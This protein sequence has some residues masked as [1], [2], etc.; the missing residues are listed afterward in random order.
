MKAIYTPVRASISAFFFCCFISTVSFAQ[1][2]IWS[3][4][5]AARPNGSTTGNQWQ[6]DFV[7]DCDPIPGTFNVVGSAFVIEDMEGS[8]CFGFDSGSND[9]LMTIGPID[10][11]SASCL[12]VGYTVTASGDFEISGPGADRLV[13][14]V[15]LDGATV[16]ASVYIS[17]NAIPGQGPRVFTLPSGNN[18]TI[19]IQGGTQS[20]SETYSISNMFIRDVGFEPNISN[21]S[22]CVDQVFPLLSLSAP[23]GPGVW[24]GQGVVANNWVTT[25]LTPG[26]YDLTFTPN[27][28]CGKATTVRG[29]LN[30]GGQAGDATIASC[31]STN[32]AIFDL[33]QA[34]NDIRDGASGQVVWYK[35]ANK[36]VQIF[37][38]TT[39]SATNG[40]IVYGAYLQSGSCPS[41]VGEVQ[42]QIQAPNPP[43]PVDDV[44]ACLS[45]TLPSLGAGLSYDSHS[46]GDVITADEVITIMTGSGACISS[47]SYQ[48]TILPAPDIDPYTGITE[49]CDSLQLPAITG[50]RLTGNEAYYTGTGGT[51]TRYDT[52]SYYKNI[53]ISTLYIYDGTGSCSD[54]ESFFVDLG[55]SASLNLQDTIVCDTF[56]FLPY[57][58]PGTFLG[59]YSEA[60]GGGTTYQAGD[61]IKSSPGTATYYARAGAGSCIVEDSFQVTFRLAPDIASISPFDVC[62]ALELP[63][64]AGDL[65][66]GNEAYFTQPGGQGLRFTEGTMI[67]KTTTLYVYDRIGSCYEELLFTVYVIPTPKLAAV[68]DTVVCD[69]LV[70]PV[71]EGTDLSGAQGYW[72]GRDGTGT[73]YDSGAVITTSQM[74]YL[75]DERARCNAQDSFQ[76]T[77]NVRPQITGPI[78]EEYVCDTF[79]LPA[80]TGNSL[81][82]NEVITTLPMGQGDTILAGTQYTDSTTL[83]LFGGV[84]GCYAEDSLRLYINPQPVLVGLPDVDT[85]DFWVLP[86]IEGQNLTSNVAY[87]DSPGGLGETY[88][89]GDTLEESGTYYI[90]DSTEIGCFAEDTF[91]LQIGITPILTHIPDT[92]ACGSFTLPAF[93]GENLQAPAYLD[94][95]FVPSQFF[96]EGQVI[97]TD[98]TIYIYDADLGCSDTTSFSVRVLPQVELETPYRDTMVCDSMS[99]EAILGQNLT[100]NEAYFDA[101]GGLGTSYR[102]GDIIRDSIRLFI[103]DGR[104]TCTDQDTLDIYVQPT[105]VL[106]PIADVAVCDF[107]ILPGLSGQNITA[108]AAYFDVNTGARFVAGDTIFVNRAMEAI[109]SN[110]FG[111]RSVQA[112]GIQITPTPQLA[113]IAD[114]E[115]CDSLVLP[116][117]SGQFL[118]S[119]VSYF[120]DTLGAGFRL[121]AG[122][123]IEVSQTLFVYADSLG[124]RDEASFAVSVNYT[125][126]VINAMKDTVGCFAVEIPVLNG[127]DLSPNTGYY[128]LPAGNGSLVTLPL[129]LVSDTTLYLFGNNATCTTSDTIDVQVKRIVTDILVTDSIECFGDAGQIELQNMISET[130]FNLSWNDPAF[131]GSEIL[132]GIPAGT[133]SVTITDPNN[134]TL[135]T[136]IVLPQPDLLVL[137]CSIANQVTVPNGS[138][139][140]I[141]LNLNGGTAPYTLFL[142]GDLTDTLVFNGSA[143][144]QLDTLA[145]GNYSFMLV[146][147]LGCA[148][149]CSQT[150]T[151]PPCE[152]S[153]D[154]QAND[155]SCAGQNNGQIMAVITN[156]QAPLQIVWNDTTFN[157]MTDLTNLMAGDY[158]VMVT[159]VN[160]CVDSAQATIIDPAPLTISVSQAQPVSGPD[161][162]DGVANL[163]FTGG[164]A[165]YQIVYDGPQTDTIS[166]NSPTGLSVDS[167]PQG[168]YIFGVID[169]NNCRISATVTITN[170][171]CGMSVTINK[172]DQQCPNTVDGELIPIVSGGVAPYQFIWSDGVTDSIRSNLPEGIYNLTVL[173]DDNCVTAVSDTIRVANP[174]PSLALVSDTVRCDSTCQSFEL[175]LNGTAPFNFSWELSR[176]LDG[177]IDTQTG[178]VGAA[179][180]PDEVLTFCESANRMTL[181]VNTLEDANCRL[182][183][184][185][186][187][188]L[189]I[190]PVPVLLLNDT[191]CQDDTRTIEGQVFD[192]SHPADTIRLINQAANGCDS[193]LLVNLTFQ[194]TVF[195]TLQETICREDSLV[196][197][198]NVYNFDVPGGTETFFGQ[199]ATGCDSVLFIDLSFYPIDTNFVSATLCDQEVFTVA[200][201]I[202]DVNRPSGLVVLPGAATTG[203][204]SIISVDINFVPEYRTDI[205]E[206]ICLEDSLIVNGNRY[207]RFRLSGT[208]TIQTAGGCDSIITI[209]LSLFPVDTTYYIQTLCPGDS[210][211]VN[212]VLYNKTNLSGIQTLENAAATGCDSIISVSIDYYPEIRTSYQDTL[213]YLDSLEVN[214][215]I[216]H[217][218]RP[219]G[220][221]IFEG[222]GRNGCDSIVEIDLEFREPVM[223]SLS[224]STAIC[225]GETA[226]LVLELSGADVYT[227]YYQRDSDV[228]I[229]LEGLVDGATIPVSPVQTSIYQ[230]MAVE[231]EGPVCAGTPYGE[232]VQVTVSEM[233]INLEQSVDYNGFGVSCAGATDG[234]LQVD[235]SGGVE[236]YNYQWSNGRFGASITGLAAGTYAVTIVD[237][238][239][240]Q[241]SISQILLEPSVLSISTD[242]YSSKCSTNPNGA[243][244]LNSV[245]GGVMP[246]EYSLDGPYFLP[247]SSLP[248][249]AGNLAPGDYDFQVQDNNG[250][251]VS[252]A[253]TIEEENLEITFQPIDDLHIG[254]SV[255]LIPEANFDLTDFTWRPLDF[256][257]DSRSSQP[258]VSPERTTIYTITAV[259]S[260]GCQVSAMITVFVDQQRR[261]YAPTAFTPNEDGYN[262]RFTIFGASDLSVIEILQIYDR[263]G[264]LLY[265]EE[266]LPPNDDHFG[267]NGEHRDNR[268][269]TGP[270]VYRAILRFSNGSREEVK[271]EVALFR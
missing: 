25:G 236:P 177:Q 63:A 47:T 12:Q 251:Q 210:L 87:Y 16:A 35:D 117:I 151:A 54:E 225:A 38:P 262:D 164:T 107:Y 62:D 104:E 250:C 156:S 22:A 146:D 162:N 175:S 192:R 261:V 213:C 219:S 270:Y 41:E 190:L 199:S 4:D 49:A 132:N 28:P 109:D 193:L 233:N 153:V 212:G 226:N 169:A 140:R 45:Y 239:G 92:L 271:G 122:T 263:W 95:P 125:P 209:D 123:K 245:S 79:S 36:S 256:L 157:G 161:A 6:V 204:D 228:P 37:N 46:V 254:D 102:A 72:T 59:Y 139:G 182:T 53:G 168:V 77:V 51:G 115:V 57:T 229:R 1:T 191:L 66:S 44:E 205:T 112:F 166:S 124:C 246:Y 137:D 29:T 196:I 248:M 234:S 150:I 5:F 222:Q 218:G 81:F 158:S 189:E 216:Y 252:T 84:E 27:D 232:K 223:A 68:E 152:L 101:P 145:A 147:G 130:P 176:E 19:Q 103:F 194:P 268:M 266:N 69:S 78:G 50:Q 141:D 136:S 155:I 7:T 237:E 148:Q 99:L 215:T 3:D 249:T 154:L 2:T 17:D 257:S 173:D 265:E 244:V 238:A 74:L 231:R 227:I 113:G 128:T 85:C 126:R 131:N 188:S 119:S 48:V 230:L 129:T 14:T 221:E 165:P 60:N 15:L 114:Q 243:V 240:C 111:C 89:P 253:I 269:P 52:G 97:A 172:Q 203:C 42:L 143:N 133:Y 197:N 43:D 21:F 217:N 259:D 106:D 142:S 39:Y 93:S 90:Y 86:E 167:L 24:S 258:F 184:D 186:T 183:L 241:D 75:Y 11:S 181:R 208:E 34:D 121:S 55:E 13:I 260:S 96:T 33:T 108:A 61:G 214:G 91:A 200:G 170:P 30:G 105:P 31:S 187:F 70:L 118:P 180:G 135:D 40:T 247:I 9:N 235:V 185:T 64:I 10:V 134:C 224:G 82:G 98:R 198:G 149:T 56:A 207:D 94:D 88:F 202:F 73:V 206:T 80:I 100:G 18:I 178:I 195:D 65:L 179:N 144:L 220:L 8:G 160:A 58:G 267:W 26:N 159:D 163:S 67:D 71:I 171:N 127:V 116:A 32:T 264:N 211:L 120:T 76:I 23:F 242:F 20:P 255:R 174:L 83:Y 138:D 201:S 110:A